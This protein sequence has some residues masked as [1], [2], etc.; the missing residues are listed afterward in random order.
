MLKPTAKEVI[1]IT[2]ARKRDRHLLSIQPG[3][4]PANREEQ[5]AMR[6]DF[7]D[8]PYELRST[9][10]PTSKA[11]IADAR[12]YIET[13][14]GQAELLLTR[15]YI[16]GELVR[17][18]ILDI[19]PNVDYTTLDDIENEVWSR[20][21]SNVHTFEGESEFDTWLVGVAKRVT[22]DVV[23][24]ERAA[25]R[26]ELVSEQVFE[27]TE[28]DDT[29]VPYYEALVGRSLPDAEFTEVSESAEDAASLEMRLA[30]VLAFLP[31][32]PPRE[33]QVAYMTFVQGATESEVATQLGVSTNTVKGYLKEVRSKMRTPPFRANYD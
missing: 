25:K 9:P 11:D 12:E 30:A 28:G 8:A 21:V 17:K 23:R 33:R 29:S 1:H 32:L 10:P 18:S 22:V 26:G 6:K 2:E 4:P 14:E 7:Y 16:K 24:K 13:P 20:A 5:E 27:Y 19:M 15:R 3:L 31:T